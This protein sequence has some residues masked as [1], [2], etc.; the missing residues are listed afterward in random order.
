L[1]G[2]YDDINS[3]LNINISNLD[4]AHLAPSHLV[5][6]RLPQD[7]STGTGRKESNKKGKG[8]YLQLAHAYDLWSENWG[9]R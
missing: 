9:G 3:G 8:N 1:Q 6:S 7:L 4:A 2:L 5:L